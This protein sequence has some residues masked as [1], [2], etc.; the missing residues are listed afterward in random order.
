MQTALVIGQGISF[1]PR[2]VHG[3]VAWSAGEQNVRES[4]QVIILT[5][6]GERL[7][8]ADFGAGLGSYLF[9]PN[10]VTTRGQIQDRIVKALTLWEPRITLDSVAVEEASDDPEAVRVTVSYR[11][12]ATQVREAVGVTVRLAG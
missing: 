7:R 4:I 8:R 1:P 3:R 11:L 5:E 9:E 10:T 6:L 12:V 2:L